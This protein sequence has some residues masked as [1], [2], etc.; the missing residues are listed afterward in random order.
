MASDP[1]A[2]RVA[3]GLLPINRLA[4]R[5]VRWTMAERMAHHGV[6]AASVAVMEGGEIAWAEGYGVLDRETNRPTQADTIFMGASTSKPVTAMLVLQHVERGVLDLDADIHTYVKSWHLPDNEFLGQSPV[7][8]RRCLNHTAGINVNGWP[9]RPQGEPLAT[10]RDLLDGGPANPHPP[11]TVNKVPGG[12]ER[13]SGGGLLLA[14]MAI[15]E[16][17]GRNFADLAQE[18]IFD[19]LGMTHSTFAHPLPQKYRAIVAHGHGPEGEAIPGG[20][21][22]SSEMGAGGIFTSAP[23]YARFMLGCRAAWLGKPGAIL[24]RDLAEQMMGSYPQTSFGQGWQMIGKGASRRFNHGG[25]NGG[26]QCEANCYLESGDGGVVMTSAVPG[27][28][29]FAEVHNA[30]ADVYGWPDFLT[31]PRT[32]NPLSPEEEANLVSEYRIVSGIELPLLKVWKED[33]ILK[34]HIE[35]LRAGI[36]TMNRDEHGNFFTQMGPFETRP[37]YAPN[38]RV[39]ALTTYAAGDTVILSAVRD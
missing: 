9:V 19:P 18:M 11:L 28:F 15:E 21:M 31:P 29:L 16:T 20:W 39:I 12:V 35:G 2:Q 25:S 27:L 24:G 26:Y 14:Q 23:D 30:I 3:N 5:D 13:Y 38:G 1:K 8:L 4:G 36:Q 32:L 10:V 37:T 34:S 7:T 22:V 6:P 17:T 33:G